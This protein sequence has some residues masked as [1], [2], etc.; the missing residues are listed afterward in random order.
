VKVE[1]GPEE[2]KGIAEAVAEIVAARLQA[3]P[4]PLL[5]AEQLAEHLGVPVGWLYQRTRLKDS[6]R[7]PHAKVGKYV[8]FDLG[9]VLAWLKEQGQDEG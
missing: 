5:S 7:I 6:G 8:R 3:T 2:I 4:G 1:L 9:E